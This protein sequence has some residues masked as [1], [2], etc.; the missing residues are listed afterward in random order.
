M[1]LEKI[2]EITCKS[3]RK[4]TKR[5][6]Q[7]G[8]VTINGKTERNGNRNVDSNLHEIF[9]GGK[10]VF[11]DHEYYL[12]NKPAGV[13]TARQD[14]DHQ[15]VTDLIKTDKELTPVGRLD[16]DTTGLMLLTDNG[17]LVYE[18]L[19]PE[20]KVE[21]TYEVWVNE[22]LTSEDIAAF[23][24]GIVFHGGEKCQ[25]AIL[26]IASSDPTISR[27]YVTIK[28]GKFHQVKKMFLACGKKVIRLNRVRLGPL[29]LPE[30]LAEGEYRSL[31]A[32][33]LQTLAP[34]FR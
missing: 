25:P 18:L 28:E 27:G 12:L 17:Q 32:A 15:T 1:R 4:M 13:V 16:R 29:V 34:F 10:Q 3:S 21:K 8:K 24:E 26:E 23:A 9:I 6:L 30:D 22:S 14:K 2:I 7:T 31:T 5:L 33:E 11:T 19:L 20:K